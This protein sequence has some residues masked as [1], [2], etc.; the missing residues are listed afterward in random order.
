MKIF[1]VLAFLIS[2]VCVADEAEYVHFPTQD[3]GVVYADYY[4]KGKPAIVLAHGAIFNRKRWAPLIE[5]LQQQNISVL[6]ID[7]RGY[8]DSKADNLFDK[9]KDILAA[10]AY[11]KRQVH[12]PVMV[13]G[14]SMGG[15]AAGEAAV[16]AS[17]GDIQKLIL[18]SPAPFSG[19]EQLKTDLLVIASEKEPMIAM[20]KRLY[21]QASEPKKLVLLKG[22]AHAQHIFKTNEKEHLIQTI[23]D[24]VHD[25]R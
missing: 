20:I 12:Y 7:F 8:G 5:A 6:A 13:L 17:A 15:A 24:F 16:K 23:I 3:G 22:R 1:M 2:S 4:L 10:V 25:D 14:A 21:K 11:L 9:P 18:L 19:I